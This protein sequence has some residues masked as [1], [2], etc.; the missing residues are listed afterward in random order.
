MTAE[1]RVKLYEKPEAGDKVSLEAGNPAF[2]MAKEIGKAAGC[3]VRV[4]KLRASGR[5]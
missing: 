2:I 4:L 3:R 5:A 1:G